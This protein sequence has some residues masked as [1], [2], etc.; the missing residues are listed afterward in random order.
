MQLN[1]VCSYKKD[2]MKDPARLWK[3]A[4]DALQDDHPCYDLS[5]TECAADTQCMPRKGGG[6]QPTTA[7]EELRRSLNKYNQVKLLV[8]V[9]LLVYV[10]G[11]CCLHFRTSED[12]EHKRHKYEFVQKVLFGNSGV[13]LYIFALIIFTLLLIIFM[14]FLAKLWSYRN[15]AQRRMQRV[16]DTMIR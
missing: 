3:A 16:L 10:A 9:V 12:D 5:A 6:C 1:K 13:M 15:P 11:I 8:V 4:R 2:I 14:P 7:A